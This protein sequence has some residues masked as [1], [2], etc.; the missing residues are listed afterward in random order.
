MPKPIRRKELIKR[1]KCFGFEGPFPG[2]NH[3]F[4]RRD[5]FKVRIP[6]EHGSNI[7]ENLISRIL[8]QANILKEEWDKLD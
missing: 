3:F 2:G 8:K 5:N 6:N 4:M 1:L 7:S